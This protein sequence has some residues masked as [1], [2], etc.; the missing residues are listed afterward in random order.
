MKSLLLYLIFTALCIQLSGQGTIIEKTLEQ[1]NATRNYSLYLPA[2]YDAQQAYPLVINYHGF[3]GTPEQQMAIS[4]MNAVADT[5]QFI[6][7]YPLALEVFNPVLNVRGAGWN[8][9]QFLDSTYSDTEF[10]L[11]MIAAIRQ[12]HAIDSMRI[13]ATGWSFGSEMALSLACEAPNVIASVAGVAESMADFVRLTC[14][15]QRPYSLMTIHG[16]ADN[17]IPFEGGAGFW[18]AAPETPAYFAQL[19]GCD[20]TPTSIE[21]ENIND[22]DNS[23]VTL[24]EYNNC[25]ADTEVLFYQI[26]G[27]GHAWPGG[28]GSGVVNQ[29]INGSTE[30]W[31]FFQRNPMPLFSNTKEIIKEHTSFSNIHPTVVR[32][33]LQLQSNQLTP[34]KYTLFDLQ[35]KRLQEGYFTGYQ[36]LSL[37]NLKSGIYILTCTWNG[38]IESHR[39]MKRD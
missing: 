4:N 31:D 13:H 8:V 22:T 5:A 29:D 14:D 39:F 37:T 30:I 20:E 26:N 15:P 16:T 24:F 23:T 21:L 19:N 7:A 10:T 25:E 9:V 11:N 3:G 38:Q 12:D 36:R 6:V 33:E 28:L 18:S 35:G 34:T 17:L 2:E 27:G 1:E 32:D